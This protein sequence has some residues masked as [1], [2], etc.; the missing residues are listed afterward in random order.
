MLAREAARRWAD[1]QGCE[2]DLPAL[3]ALPADLTAARSYALGDPAG[4]GSPNGCGWYADYLRGAERGRLPDRA[5]GSPLADEARLESCVLGVSPAQT[6]R[7]HP[8][9]SREEGGDVSLRLALTRGPWWIQTQSY[10]GDDAEGVRVKD[11]RV[12]PPLSPGTAGRTGHVTYGSATCHGAPAL[13]TMTAASSYELAVR[14]RF[15]GLFEAYATETAARRG[16]TGLALP[17][18]G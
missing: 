15:D 1:R 18:R 3:P 11:G 8:Q 4:S 13:F 9:L 2:T 6:R 7:I 5:L 14:P 12:W 10:F 16:C 17:G